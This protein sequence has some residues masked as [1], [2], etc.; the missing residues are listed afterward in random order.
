MIGTPGT[1]IVLPVEYRTG[2][3]VLVDPPDPRLHK[4]TS[5]AGVD[6]LVDV[7][8]IRDDVGLYHVAWDAPAGAMLGT[9][10]IRW[11]GTID[12]VL[13]EGDDVLDLIA[14]GT[15]GASVYGTTVDDVRPLL[16][17]RLISAASKPTEAQVAQ[18][19]DVAANWIRSRLG[20]LSL[21]PAEVRVDVVANAR[22]LAALGAA[23]L[24]ELAG[25]PERAGMAN[26]GYGVWLWEQFKAGIDEALEALNKPTG[27][28]P[29]GETPISDVP[30]IIAPAPMFLRDSGF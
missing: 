28:T 5:P 6:E 3:G 25:A 1:T 17:H 18:M 16:P 13:M 26:A 21:L 2:A 22:G 12:G 8:P 30:A 14:A 10:P 4:L 24:A 19:I 29:G 9:W 11:T 15:I 20:D 27:D 7:I 23:A